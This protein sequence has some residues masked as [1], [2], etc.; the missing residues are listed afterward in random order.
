MRSESGMAMRHTLRRGMGVLL[1]SLA[2]LG[3]GVAQPVEEKPSTAGDADVRCEA[4][5]LEGLAP[6]MKFRR[7]EE[8]LK[9]REPRPRSARTQRNYTPGVGWQAVHR[10]HVEAGTLEVWY[11]VQVAKHK[12]NPTAVRVRLLLPE[13]S[14]TPEALWQSVFDRLGP[15]SKWER[16][17]CDIKAAVGL[18]KNRPYTT[19][20]LLSWDRSSTETED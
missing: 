13:E 1:V 14:T 5:T 8:L 4:F 12:E 19:L 15:M 9:E 6:G 7:V 11:P 10:W 17:D 20:T 3:A 18:E 2:T 16:E